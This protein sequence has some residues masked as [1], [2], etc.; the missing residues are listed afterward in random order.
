MKHR[1]NHSTEVAAA[2]AG[3]SAATGYRI[4]R[5]PTLPSLKRA[6]RGR[7]RPDPLAG[8]FD[9][10]VVP[11]LET[12]SDIRPVAVFGELMQRHPD[13]DPS[14]RRTLER[15][16]RDWRARHGPDRDVM[17][18]Q[19]HRPG[20]LGLSDF[21]R[22]E[23]LGVTIAGQKLDHMLYHFR[24]AWSGFRHAEV[25]LGGES[26]TALAEGLQAALWSL[27]GA[28]QEHRTDS[29]S[30][31]FR[32]LCRQDAQ[33]M[34]ERY[35][36]LCRHYGMTPSRNNRGVA[37]EN[38][39]IESAHG[40]LK[41]EI[42]DALALRG[43]KEF[44]DLAAW[45]GF[46]A[47]IVG[48]GNA[49]RARRI[50]AERALLR[51]LPPMRTTDYEETSVRVTTSSGFI[52]KRVFYTVPSRLIGHRLGVRL[53]DDRL[54]LYLG[55]IHQ[56][57]VPRKRRGS[58]MKAVH[59]VN[60]RHVIHSLKTKPMAL[61][62]LVYRDELFPREAYRRCFEM[63]MAQLDERSACR[64]TVKLL[65]L[66]HEE[67]CEA[68]LAEEIDACLRAG[69]LPELDRLK[70]RFAPQTG[71][72]PDIRVMRAPLAGYGELLDTAGQS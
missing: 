2:K 25:V 66:A 53:Y 71:A 60:Y 34:T 6:P 16:I 55:G 45:R 18:Q 37:H 21:T 4:N 22:M 8:I 10:E 64:L 1:K 23:A 20:R 68:A 38:G 54:E 41:R 58:S 14:I 59:V 36:L 40:H 72:M 32:N 62:N 12:D 9:S 56:L 42:A 7:R 11:L 33:D 28:P 50:K 67:N 13:L 43:S 46:V 19:T 48:R 26:F 47:E 51:D 35:R 17:F 15:R 63:A 52:L 70:V 65:A 29:L 30:A 31:G 39:A 69:K 61:L 57:T 5:D 24:L 49:R 27:G 44:A 3:F